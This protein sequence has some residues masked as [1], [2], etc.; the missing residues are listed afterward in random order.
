MG[1][2]SFDFPEEGTAIKGPYFDSYERK[3]LSLMS[4]LPQQ[5]KLG[6]G[7]VGAKKKFFFVSLS[8]E[9]CFRLLKT[10]S[11]IKYVFEKLLHVADRS[12]PQIGP[13]AKI[14]QLERECVSIKDGQVPSM[15][16]DAH[17]YAGMAWDLLSL[18]RECSVNG[19]L[20]SQVCL[21]GGRR[22][23]EKRASATIAC[24]ELGTGLMG[25]S[26]YP[27]IP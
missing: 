19:E 8:L 21:M 15:I 16:I 17:V 23:E 26:M 6:F 13:W 24:W 2:F 14:K 18:S 25:T 4:A 5:A 1:I 10:S 7:M 20:S 12:F 27:G 22:G 3:D 9:I 11:S